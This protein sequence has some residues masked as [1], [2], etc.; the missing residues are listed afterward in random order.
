M[1]RADAALRLNPLVCPDGVRWPSE[2][3]RAEYASGC[4]WADPNTADPVRTRRVVD[5]PERW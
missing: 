4:A 1:P 3:Y 2:R 5:L